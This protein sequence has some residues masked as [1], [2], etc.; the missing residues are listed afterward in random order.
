MRGNAPVC[1]VTKVRVSLR[2]KAIG[3]QLVDRSAAKATGR[4]ADIMDHQQIDVACSRAGVAIGR[5]DLAGAAQDAGVVDS[6]AIPIRIAGS[7]A[8]LIPRRSIR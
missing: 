7:R 1:D 3:K 2:I 8:Q 6:P 5:S 4:Q